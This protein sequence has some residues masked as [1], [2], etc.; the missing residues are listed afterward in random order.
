MKPSRL[1]WLSRKTG[2]IP[3][4]SSNREHPSLFRTLHLVVQPCFLHQSFLDRFPPLLLKG[5][6]GGMSGGH[7]ESLSAGN[8]HEV[9]NRIVS[10]HKRMIGL[11]FGN[12]QCIQLHVRT[13]Q[14]DS[15]L[16]PINKGFFYDGN[17]SLMSFSSKS[18]R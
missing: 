14:T 17:L 3:D 18:V 10:A 1:I 6:T 16:A 7:F 8:I 4:T 9:Q 2:R 11:S 12:C 5:K 15:R 13:M